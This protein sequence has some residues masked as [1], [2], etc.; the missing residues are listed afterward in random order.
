MSRR[1][2]SVASDTTL[3]GVRDAINQASDNPG[4]KA[5][6]I[7]VD[8]GSQLMLTSDKVGAANTLSVVATDTDVLDANDLT[9]LDVCSNR[10]GCHYLCR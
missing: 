6:I 10:Y 7:K 4:I 3:T 9:R 1:C 5:S 8:S 2:V